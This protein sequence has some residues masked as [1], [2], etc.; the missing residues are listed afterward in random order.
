MP[1]TD[2]EMRHVGKMLDEYSDELS[3]HGCNDYELDNTQDNW[4]MVE[5]MNAWNEKTTVEEWRKSGDA[6]KRPKSGHK[7]VITDWFLAAYLA[8]RAR[9]EA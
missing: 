5:R 9:G 4:D 7:I 6:R 3:N 8:A 1:L 2:N